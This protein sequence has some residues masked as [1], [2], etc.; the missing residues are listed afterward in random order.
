M[1]SVTVENDIDFYYTRY[2][3]NDGYN[4]DDDVRDGGDGG[5][6]CDDNVDD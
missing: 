3:L 1:I 5:D 4:D 6:C 2:N